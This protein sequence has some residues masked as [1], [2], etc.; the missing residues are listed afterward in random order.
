M[1]DEPKTND[2]QE[3]VDPEVE[4]GF[5]SSKKP[6]KL[7]RNIVLS[8][9]GTLTVALS[10]WMV[11]ALPELMK[12]FEP[13]PP[14]PLTAE[15]IIEQKAKESERTASW[16]NYHCN[17]FHLYYDGEEAE[18]PLGEV[19]GLGAGAAEQAITDRCRELLPVV[20]ALGGWP[21]SRPQQDNIVVCEGFRFILNGNVPLAI[22][23]RRES[24][25][26]GVVDV[27]MGD[28]ELRT[29][30]VYMGQGTR[31][32]RYAPLVVQADDQCVV[33]ATLRV[34]RKAAVSGRVV[35]ATEKSQFNSVQWRGDRRTATN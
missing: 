25:T 26:N 35:R 14:P 30:N 1:N 11:I 33:V 34:G 18:V 27:G 12:H 9:A 8:C 22:T 15:Q 32:D 7:V 5:S 4:D 20:R 3:D 24:L 16:Q 10:V 31:I 17:L 29:H 28:S 23:P 2:Q 21:T 19:L 13:P 6:D